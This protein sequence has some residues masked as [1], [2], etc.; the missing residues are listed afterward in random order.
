MGEQ[1]FVYQVKP[2]FR[3]GMLNELGEGDTVELTEAEAAG[4]RD[5]LRLV[6]PATAPTADP[7][8]QDPPADS[9]KGKK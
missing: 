9:G 6:E 2:G 1:K 5:K 3:F 4:F 8:A 7:P